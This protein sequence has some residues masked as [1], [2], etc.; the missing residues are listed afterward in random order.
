[1]KSQQLESIVERIR[2]P[3]FALSR[4]DRL[5]ECSMILGGVSRVADRMDEWS[6]KRIALLPGNLLT[7]LGGVA[8]V[9]EVLTEFAKTIIGS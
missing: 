2:L 1:M 7:E 9:E 6:S 5:L 4:L 8:F 3:G